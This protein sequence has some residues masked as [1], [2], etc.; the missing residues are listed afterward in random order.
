MCGRVTVRFA[1]HALEPF[2]VILTEPLVPRYNVAPSQGLPVIRVRD[3]QRECVSLTWGL[4]PR[5]AKDTS[6]A[7]GTRNA[8]S[9]TITTK[10]SFRDAFRRRRCLVMVSSFYEWDRHPGARFKQPYVIELADGAAM[11]F[12][13]LW[14]S[15]TPPSGG[16]VLETCTI[17]TCAPNEFMARLHDRMPVILS[18]A[19]ADR[20]LAPETPPAELQSLL[21]PLE[22]EMHAY[23]VSTRMNSAQND[24]P[25]C[26]EPL[27]D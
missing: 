4:V 26:I 16:D 13:G 8:K 23:P 10:P 3:G 11:A 20:W 25:E 12:A 21:V 17:A 18:P 14:E 19:A 15:W 2:G 9:E 5:W 7:A 27:T 1:P 6:I 24:G 22:G